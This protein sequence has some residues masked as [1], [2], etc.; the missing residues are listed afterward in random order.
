MKI[1]AIILAAGKGTRMKS[2][3]PKCAYPFCGKPMVKYIVENCQKCNIDIINVVVG[4]KKEQ[5]IDTCSM[6]KT[7]G[8]Q[9]HYID[10]CNEK[11]A[12]LK[13]LHSV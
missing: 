13:R 11:E 6:Q 10:Q 7:D 2:D 4:Y 8:P 1:N 9:Q 5:I 12:N 3:L